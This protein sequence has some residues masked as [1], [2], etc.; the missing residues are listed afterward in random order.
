[1][2]DKAIEA[3]VE[4]ALRDFHSDPEI[5]SGYDTVT[6]DAVNQHAEEKRIVSFTRV[7]IELVAKNRI[8][9]AVRM[10]ASELFRSALVREENRILRDRLIR[11]TN[12]VSSLEKQLSQAMKDELTGLPSRRIF[13][14]KLLSELARLQRYE[15]EVALLFCDIDHFK[16]INDTYGHEAGDIV[17]KEV[18]A[19]MGKV[20]PR[21]TDH[22][23]RFGGEE[24]VACLVN[25]NLAN[26]QKKA[27]EL[28]LAV[29]KID[30]PF[31]KIT[32][33]IGCSHVDVSRLHQM[34]E[35]PEWSYWFKKCMTGFPKDP[36]LIPDMTAA[37]LLFAEADGLLYRAKKKGRNRVEVTMNPEDLASLR[38]E[39]LRKIANGDGNGNSSVK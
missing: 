31:G 2:S 30:V 32:I 10:M 26:A 21:P 34:R 12:S 16:R 24:L 15:G 35:F 25:C 18:A 27:E 37:K 3:L 7:L 8:K 22:L 1:M 17:L 23:C 39:S 38:Q 4:G 20:I 5:L 19:V 9:D 13:N 29:E 36:N 33:S 6:V 11:I 28:R 14:A